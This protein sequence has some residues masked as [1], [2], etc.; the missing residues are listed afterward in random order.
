MNSK[1]EI[2]EQKVIA[3]IAAGMANKEIAGELST[4]TQSIKDKIHKLLRKYNCR[5]RTELAMKFTSLA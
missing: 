4:T 3:M 5:N 2:Q 1:K